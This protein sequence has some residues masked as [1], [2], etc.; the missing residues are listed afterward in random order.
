MGQQEIIEFLEANPDGWFTAVEL[1]EALSGN[2]QG[3]YSSL[4]KLRRSGCVQF[5]DRRPSGGRW[6]SYQ[7]RHKP[8][9][10]MTNE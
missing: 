9:G 4:R 6:Q 5:R 7:Y 10:G 1:S 3:I 2:I 8:E